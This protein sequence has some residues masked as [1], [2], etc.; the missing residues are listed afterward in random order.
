MS[1]Y[2]TNVQFAQMHKLTW[3]VMSVV[4]VFPC[5]H[6]HGTKMEKSKNID[7]IQMKQTS[8]KSMSVAFGHTNVR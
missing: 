2:T 8:L 5:V 7:L 3:R 6:Q 1:G 4:A